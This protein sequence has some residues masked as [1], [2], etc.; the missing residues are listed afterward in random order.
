MERLMVEG[1]L[2]IAL[3]VVLEQEELPLRGRVVATRVQRAAVVVALE[4]AGQ[5][6]AGDPFSLWPVSFKNVAN[7]FAETASRPIANP[8]Q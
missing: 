8:G 4:A 1:L 7:D 3:L 5:L 6:N 2:G